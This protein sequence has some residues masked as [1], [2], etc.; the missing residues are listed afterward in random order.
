MTALPDRRHSARLPRRRPAQAADPSETTL[1]SSPDVLS[2]TATATRLMAASPR[3]VAIS[4]RAC[5]FS[6]SRRAT[7]RQLPGAPPRRRK[8]HFPR[9][10]R[11]GCPD[12]ATRDRNG[13]ARRDSSAS[14]LVELAGTR[15]SSVAI[16]TVSPVRASRRASLFV[17][18]RAGTRIPR[19][20]LHLPP[21][22]LRLGSGQ[23]TIRRAARQV[24]PP[25][26]CDVKTRR[27]PLSVATATAPRFK[28]P[29]LRHMLRSAPCT[30]ESSPARADG[31]ADERI[32]A[33]RVAFGFSLIRPSRDDGPRD[34]LERLFRRPLSPPHA[35]ELVLLRQ[36]SFS[37][38]APSRARS[39]CGGEPSAIDSA[40]SRSAAISRV[41]AR[42]VSIAGSSPSRGTAS[43]VA[44][45]PGLR[46]PAPRA[47]ARRRRSP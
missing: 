47:S 2:R 13:D 16:R 19:G 35:R 18:R 12:R 23:A 17:R 26:R 34:D 10:R 7:G 37:S 6:R 4:S 40:S 5:A 1:T 30:T 38:A 46:P 33:A 32:Y 22:R 20:S 11:R 14:P 21:T 43:Q 42:A 24:G 28:P 45:D 41:R 29:V 27:P 44:E 31:Q 25:L 9:P 15:G 8:P 3:R 36:P 39:P